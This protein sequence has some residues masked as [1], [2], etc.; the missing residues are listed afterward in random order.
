MR[1]VRAEVDVVRGSPPADA[2]WLAADNAA[3]IGTY[4][5]HNWGHHLGDELFPAFRLLRRFGMLAPPGSPATA[6]PLLIVHPNCTLGGAGPPI[7][8]KVQA[9]NTRQLLTRRPLLTSGSVPEGFFCARNLALGGSHYG[10]KHAGDG[11]WVYFGAHLLARAGRDPSARPRSQRILLLEKKGKRAVANVRALAAHLARTFGVPTD[12]LNPSDLKF[13][14]QMDAMARTTVLITPCGGIAF[15]SLFL[16]PGAAMV[17]VCYHEPA[18]GRAGSI[19]NVFRTSTSVAAL[20]YPTE[21]HEARVP[22]REELAAL[23]ER[24]GEHVQPARDLSVIE[25]DP[26]KLALV[27]HAA[28]LHAEAH[29]G[30]PS[31]SFRPP[32]PGTAVY[33]RSAALLNAS[34]CEAMLERAR[35]ALPG[36]EVLASEWGFGKPLGDLAREMEGTAAKKAMRGLEDWCR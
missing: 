13:P 2:P 10:I 19:E 3:L 30:L 35:E 9:A 31:P 26:R 33:P 24:Y 15:S 11:D 6:D 17:Y 7:G 14:A 22:Q 4:W 1:E 21:A 34:R 23:R 36:R 5:P 25:P 29:M 12:V 20:Y 18:T 32:G 28:L 16:P 8:C 27:V